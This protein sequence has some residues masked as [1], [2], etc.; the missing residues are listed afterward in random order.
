MNISRLHLCSLAMF[1]ATV[2][3]T[4]AEVPGG[5]KFIKGGTYRPIF[6]QESVERQIHDY[7][8]DERQVTNEE[9]LQFVQKN[10]GWRRSSIPRIFADEQYLAKWAG[11][12]ELGPDADPGAPVT[13]ISWFAARAYLASVGKRLPNLDEWE[14][15]ARAD[16][17][18]TDATKDPN[19]AAKLL[20]WYSRPTPARMPRADAAPADVYGL[21]GMHGVVWEW[22]NDFNNSMDTGE[23]RS[24]G[25]IER[26]LYCA[27]GS[28]ALVD[29]TDYAAFM[30][31]ALRTSLRASF[32]MASLGFRGA[33]SA[34]TV[35]PTVT[36]NT[37]ITH[38]LPPGSIYQLGG[39]W[40]NQRDETVALRALG[41]KW[42]V[43]CM[44]YTFCKAACPRISAIMRNI[45]RD[46]SEEAKAR[47]TFTFASFDPKDDTPAQLAKHAK[48]S[49]LEHWNFLTSDEA[50]VME[51][52]AVLGIKYEPYD[53][54]IA[55]TNAVILLN[56]AGE[57]VARIDGL[58]ASPDPLIQALEQ[59][60]LPTDKP[61]R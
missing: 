31:Q 10:P 43:I 44:G 21:H 42:Q 45:E 3:G 57:I 2:T 54:G 9:F 50:S 60:A 12:V 46:L 6:L 56:P 49:H 5:M 34:D 38:A 8:L 17:S 23:G 26:E 24:G 37:E 47:T 55:H 28:I 51:L 11:D 29:K 19:F 58:G 40:R 36:Q 33:W 14:Y 13:G 52:A 18:T 22:I 32:T 39:V 16:E 53:G 7:Y 20:T 59:Q 30:R 25:E 41:G 48:E 15:A 27:G 4:G 35:L 61:R 1:F